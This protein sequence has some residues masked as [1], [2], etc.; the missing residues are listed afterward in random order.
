MFVP[1]FRV[2]SKTVFFQVCV[3]LPSL[4]LRVPTQ[5]LFFSIYL[6][7]SEWPIRRHFLVLICSNTG[8][9]PV[10]SHSSVLLPLAV[11]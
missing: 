4:Q 8:F 11:V 9:F 2:S 5:L 3:G 7:L 10:A 6:F 1:D